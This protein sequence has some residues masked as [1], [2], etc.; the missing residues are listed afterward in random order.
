MAVFEKS[1][2]A[3]SGDYQKDIKALTDYIAYMQEQMEYTMANIQR[4]LSAL[5]KGGNG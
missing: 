2:G 1:F 3:L 4:R 5:E